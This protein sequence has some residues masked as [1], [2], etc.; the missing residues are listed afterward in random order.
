MWNVREA[1]KALDASYVGGLKKREMQLEEIRVQVE[2]SKVEERFLFSNVCGF[3]LYEADFGWGEP[4]RVRFVGLPYKNMAFFM[5]TKTGDGIEVL[6]QLSEQD[7]EKFQAHSMLKILS[8]IPA[9]FFYPSNPTIPNSEKSKLLKKSLSNVLSIYHP[10]AGRRVGNLYVD[11]ND[12]GTPLS[13]AEADCDLSLAV[14]DPNPSNLKIF[15]PHETD[16]FHDLCLAVHATYFPCGGLAIG[17]LLSHKVADASSYLLFLKTW[18]AV[19][20][21]GGGVPLP[22]FELAAYAPQLDILSCQPPPGLVEGDVATTILTFAAAE[23]ATLQERYNSPGC[24]RPSR[25]E[26][27]SAFI[28]TRFVSATGAISDPD[29]MC[30]VYNAINLRNRAD[31]PLSDH[32]FGNFI[33][34]STAFV[35]AGD[36][37]VEVV[38]KV[39]EATKRIDA[40]YVAGLKKRERQLEDIMGH[41]RA[42]EGVMV[43]MFFSSLCGF[44]FTQVDFGWGRPARLKT[45][46]LPFQNLVHFMDTN[47]GDGVEALIQLSIQDMEKFQAHLSLNSKL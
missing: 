1:S 16:E 4:D 14:A 25:V 15:L 34:P 38:R 30:I 13:E 18:S 6:L 33:A 40:G 23:I 5:D 35:R 2:A 22:K 31:P 26:A 41:V 37:G 29:Q 7:M 42:S 24:R 32:Q 28:W 47:G 19:A 21:N 11:C 12:A 39:R 17:I 10:L 3:P 45:I 36:S 20:R 43:K 8:F 46:G 9:V 44:P 27:L